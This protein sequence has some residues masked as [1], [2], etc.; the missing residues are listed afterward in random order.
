[1]RKRIRVRSAGGC[2]RS[3]F[4]LA[5]LCV[6]A[7]LGIRAVR[8]QQAVLPAEDGIS[9]LTPRKNQYTTIGKAPEDIHRGGLVLVNQDAPYPS[10]GDIDLVTLWEVNH[11]SYQVKNEE[12]LV[13]RQIVEPLNDLMDDFYAV[14]HTDAVMVISGYR[15]YDYQQTLLNNEIA[16][17]GE[18][19][20][21]KWVAVPGHSEHHTG[22]AFDV[23]LY[24]DGDRKDYDG[25]GDFA[26][27]NQNAYR[28]G[29]IVRYQEN[30]ATVTGISHEPWH[31]RYVGIPHAYVM[32]QKGFCYEEYIDF[33]RE[34]RYG[35][36]HLLVTYESRSWEIY[37]TEDTEVPVPKD[38]GYSISGNNVDGFIVTA[39]Y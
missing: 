22:L 27:I 16:E 21:Y 37:Y 20:A 35:D 26:W 9:A 18:V 29:F 5:V 28:Y 25:T 10:S 30:K 33:L 32:K 17:K 15:S 12:V 3:L 31:F 23:C 39:A 13:S 8:S 38:K 7:V 34:Y 6:I 36:T 4:V 14:Y 2:F 11:D 19:E 24:D 1:M